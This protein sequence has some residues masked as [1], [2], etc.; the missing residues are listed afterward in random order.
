MPAWA[1]PAGLALGV[2]AYVWSRRRK[3]PPGGPSASGRRVM[4]GSEFVQQYARKGAAAWEAAALAIARED[5]LT[6]WPW[7]DLELTDGTNTAILK[8]QSDVLSIGTLEDYVRLPLTPTRA[9]S[10]LNLFGGLL[11][12]PWLEYQIWR[13]APAKLRPT[14]MAPNKGANL[15]QYAAHSRAIDE[16]LASAGLEPGVLVSGIKKGVVVGNFYKPGK[17]LIF[18]WYRP[19]PDVFSDGKPMNAPDRQPIQPKSNVHGE[20]YVDYSHGIRVVAP[21]ALLN[22]EVVPTIELYQH[23]TLSQL[24]SNTG[25]VRMARY[26]S[27]VAPPPF[28]PVIPISAVERDAAID[29]VARAESAPT[30]PSIT[31]HALAEISRQKRGG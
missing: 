17:V 9:Q 25:P 26:P 10:V 20:G 1:I 18:G 2:T 16:E 28:R 24:V 19:S 3:G 7:V 30:T 21:T 12:T 29:T 8:V 27:P 4:Q 31:E 5:G 23:P 14:A 15:E 22:G 13:A 6:P 11:T